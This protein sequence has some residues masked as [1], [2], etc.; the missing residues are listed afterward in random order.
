MWKTDS[1]PRPVEPEPV[2][3]PA[4]ERRAAWIGS[5]LRIEGRVISQQHLTIE[6]EVDGTI[7]VGD[8]SLTIGPGASV[9]A[10]L[11]AKTITISGTMKG[12]IKADE[13]VDLRATASVE[14]DIVTPRL[15]MVEGAVI[16]GHVD[17]AGHKR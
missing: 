6:G 9:K 16:K 7:E 1:A 4:E 14:G 3:K 10:D 5:A 2:N 13:R 12:N 15:I 11:M 17:A 8:K